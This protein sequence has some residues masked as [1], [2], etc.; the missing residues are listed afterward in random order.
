[1]KLIIT[2]VKDDD[3]NKLMRQLN[4]EGF[5]VTK[6]SSTGGF[7]K[8]GNMTLM[9]GTEEKNVDSVVKIITEHCE[10]RKQVVIPPSTSDSIGGMYSSFPIEIDVGGA[11]IFV[12]DVERFEKI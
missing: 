8:S 5:F 2:I 3:G 9:I 7:L 11:T 1:M 10:R 6:I 4:K 12:L